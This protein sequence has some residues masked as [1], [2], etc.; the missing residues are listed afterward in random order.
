MS[1]SGY[2]WNMLYNLGLQS[3]QWCLE[4]KHGPLYKGR[5]IQV[6][7]IDTPILINNPIYI[8]YVIRLYNKWHSRSYQTNLIWFLLLYFN[9]LVFHQRLWSDFILE[10]R[11][12]SFSQYLITETIDTQ[13]LINNLIYIF[14]VIR[15]YNTWHRS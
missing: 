13:I 8:F 11:Q 3:I 5:I 14:Y 2:I 7:I 12:D 4:T 10:L 9:I 15:L 6:Q 1:T